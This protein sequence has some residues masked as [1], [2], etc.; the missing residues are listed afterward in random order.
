MSSAKSIA[1]A[2][3]DATQAGIE[4]VRLAFPFFPFSQKTY[5]LASF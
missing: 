3:A 5:N 2:S 1:R 4:I